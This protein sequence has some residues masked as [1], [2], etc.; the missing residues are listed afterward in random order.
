MKGG[1]D[2]LRGAACPRCG[3]DLG[4]A[5]AAWQRNEPACC[6][7]EGVCSECG[8]VFLWRDVLRPEF[9]IRL[10]L[11]DSA[12]SV[13]P[14]V[15]LRTA[16]CVA[17]PPALW[18]RVRMT[19]GLRWRRLLAFSILTA[20]VAAVLAGLLLAGMREGVRRLDAAVTGNGLT[21]LW[22]DQLWLK[23][24]TNPGRRAF[25]V[26]AGLRAPWVAVAVLAVTIAPLTLRCLP[27]ARRFR[28]RARHLARVS[29]YGAVW[30]PPALASAIAVAHLLEAAALED[31]RAHGGAYW[32]RGWGVWLSHH[33]HA[34][35]PACVA[36][37]LWAW[38][39]CAGARY[40]RVPHAAGL[41]A[42]ISVMAFLLAVVVVMLIPGGW[43]WL[44][45]DS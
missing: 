44:L 30:L 35:G 8:L 28:V 12:P 24:V 23:D 37:W 29:L 43:R 40:L 10:Q 7:L 38:W 19:D 34:V 21:A 13:G 4:G 17:W 31:F 45:W 22:S 6:P 1:D 36:L 27:T 3:Y 18:R 42:A 25:G 5:I 41:S 32:T 15:V 33:M 20:A 9:A 39:W 14:M 2:E 26:P 11:L 16:A